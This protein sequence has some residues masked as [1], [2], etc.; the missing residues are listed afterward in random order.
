MDAKL[1]EDLF[2]RYATALERRLE[3]EGEYTTPGNAPEG[4]KSR[5]KDSEALLST[6]TALLGAYQPDP[7]QRFRMVHFYEVV[8]NSLR[9]Q[10]GSN[11]KSL[12]RAFHTLETIC[13]NLLLF[14]WKKEFRCIKT[15]TGPYVYHLQSAMSDAELRSLMRTIG[16]TC[17]HDSQFYLQEHSG[18]INHL[19]QLSFEL[20]LAQAECRLLGEVVALAR[21]SASELEALELRRGCRDDAAGCA[22]ALR[23]R[24][25]LGA[26]MARL[27]VRPLDIERP[28]AHHLRRGSRPSKSVDVTDGAGHWHAAVN[29]P[30]LKASLSLRKEPLFVDAEEDMKDEIIR[31]STSASLFSVAAPPSYSPVADFFP[32][33]SPPS[34]D[35]YTSYHLSSLDEIDLYTERGV[36]GTGG[37][38]TPS[39]PPSREPRDARD[40]W[41]L[42]AHGSVKCQGCGLGCSNM[43]SC[44]RCDMILCSACHDVDP[45]PCC[46]LQD[47]HPKSPR[48]IDGY[49][50][51]KEKLSVY[52]NTHSHSHLHPH[53]LTL[54]HSHSHPHPHPQ[55]VEKPLTS[56]KLFSSKSVALTTPKGVSSER[57]S[58]GGSRCGFCNKPSA[59]HTC[60]NCSK[61][62]CDS[63][64]GLYAK[65][66]CTRKNPQ[67]NFVPNHQLNFKSGTISHLVYR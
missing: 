58:M 19:R 39:R 8:E 40:G 7:G 12:E 47:Y 49:I 27:S 16:Y 25:S 64:M 1:K 51:V 66:M 24:D 67:H 26:D 22:E 42:K 11:L 21:G 56:A 37:R 13:T 6:A 3:E 59:S 46:G 9:C 61:V 10:R 52:S 30:V 23:R 31:P 43:A 4:G 63:C 54:T 17:D 53:P 32:I 50:P 38:Q 60:V 34:A 29:K 44:Q 5:H 14:P 55:M 45:T 33:Q 57:I 36:A 18:G 2:R 28:H 35:A 15:F 65:D 48:P 41:L 62:S 20:F